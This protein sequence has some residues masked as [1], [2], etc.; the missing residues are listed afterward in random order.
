MAPRRGPLAISQSWSCGG[1]SSTSL[2]LDRLPNRLNGFAY[3]AP[4]GADGGACLARGFVDLAFVVQVRIVGH[5]GHRLL[6]LS[7][8]RF[9]LAGDLI[10]S[11][12]SSSPPVRSARTVPVVV[13]RVGRC[14]IKVR[15]HT[16]Q[17]VDTVACG[18]EVPG[19]RLPY[20]SSTCSFCHPLQSSCQLLLDIQGIEQLI[21][22]PVIKRLVL[23]TF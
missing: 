5:I 12:F 4:G 13:R 23:R 17:E 22:D 18:P 6:R 21:Y 20:V 19:K 15:Q 3:L 7:L 14:P 1:D 10:D 8:E 11:C 9:G 16:A 2:L